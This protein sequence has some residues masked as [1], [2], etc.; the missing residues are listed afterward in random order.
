MSNQGVTMTRQF[1][2]CVVYLSALCTLAG[3]ASAEDELFSRIPIDSVFQKPTEPPTTA[4][5]NDSTEKV[6]RVLNITQ[7][8]DLL[9]EAGMEPE[10]SETAVT[11][12]VEQSKYTF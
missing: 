3:L 10:A 1:R 8:H 4:R 2:F 5:G 11:V 7:L 9:K 6:V 12:K